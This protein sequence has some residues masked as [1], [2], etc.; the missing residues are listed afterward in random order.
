MQRCRHRSR[1]RSRDYSSGNFQKSKKYLRTLFLLSLKAKMHF[2]DLPVEML[3]YIASFLPTS[4]IGSLAQTCQ[5]LL[6]VTNIDAIWQQ[7]CYRDYLVDSN[8]GWNLSF[9]EIYQK[10]LQRCGF[11]GWKRLALMPYGG[12][13]Y[14]AWGKGEI[15][16]FRYRPGEST[17]DALQYRLIYSIQWNSES[18]DLEV[19][20]Q[21]CEERAEPA[22]LQGCQSMTGPKYPVIWCA[23][24]DCHKKHLPFMRNQGSS[25][26]EFK[27]GFEDHPDAFD[28][29]FY[30]GYNC[31]MLP[32]PRWGEGDQA[33]S[34]VQLGLYAGNYGSHGV[35][36]LHLSFSE[37][38]PTHLVGLKITGDSNV[39]AGY[40][41]LTVFLDKPVVLTLADQESVFDILADD[42]A[43]EPE[44][45]V[46]LLAPRQGAEGPDLRQPFAVPMDCFDRGAQYPSTCMGRYLGIGRIAA[47]YYRRPAQCRCHFIKFSDTK[48][49]VLWLDLRSFSVF[50][51]AKGLQADFKS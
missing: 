4:S 29:T 35:E 8:D 32:F 24:E 50:H 38:N 14:V 40:P 20:C 43:R 44:A 28:R 49:A 11:L 48:F 42:E 39:P 34:P 27:Q 46:E 3:M 10:V 15:R 12:L 1:S 16:V 19:F 41:S 33:R 31:P 37:V 36:I 5:H 7:L 45:Y 51:K 18:A 6:D 13:V 47:T 22:L 2:L 30:E 17:E 26:K 25:Q 23:T 21:Q 9:K